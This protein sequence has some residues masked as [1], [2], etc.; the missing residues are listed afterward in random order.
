MIE[1]LQLYFEAFK[2][3]SQDRSGRIVSYVELMA[4]SWALHIIYAF[5]SVFVL[6]LGVKSYSYFSTSNDFTHLVLDAFNFKMQK[7]SLFT[8]LVAVVFYPF[9]FQFAYKFW[10]ALIKFYANLF[11]IQDEEMDRKS[12]EIL[13]SAFSSNLFL[14]FPIIGNILSNI[15]MAYFLFQGLRRKYEFS[16]LQASLVLLTPLFLVFLF[17]IFSASYFIFLFSLL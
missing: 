1:S 7:I 8:T 12:D 4:V 2:D 14:I 3:F 17:A 10:K 5:Y 9:I 15:G 13:S 11:D 6:Y 16:S